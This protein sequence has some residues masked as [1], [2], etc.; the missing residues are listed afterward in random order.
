[1]IASMSSSLVVSPAVRA[2]R[3]KPRHEVASA[4]P[5]PSHW[6][7]RTYRDLAGNQTLYAANGCGDDVT[8]INRATRKAKISI[9][10][11]LMPWGAVIDD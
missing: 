6:F 10:V 4:H 9:P 8:Q 5:L 3:P 11:G 2:S 1:M 7:I